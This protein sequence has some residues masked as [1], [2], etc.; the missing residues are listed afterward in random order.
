MYEQ[1]DGAQPLES[2]RAYAE[3]LIIPCKRSKAEE[4]SQLTRELMSKTI[5]R[6]TA[7]ARSA[8][9]LLDDALRC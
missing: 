7:R 4:V 5:E 3:D 1:L 8:G 9:L 2:H 6:T